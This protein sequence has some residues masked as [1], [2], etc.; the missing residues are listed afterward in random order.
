MRARSAAGM[1]RA[2]TIGLSV[3]A[4]P[5]STGIPHPC[6]S[7]NA[8]PGTGLDGSQGFEYIRGVCP[9][10]TICFGKLTF[11]P[12]QV[13]DPCPTTGSISSGANSS[14]LWAEGKPAGDFH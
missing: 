12:V 10:N 13:S 14:D 4:A 6:F 2:R 1:P 9:D 8:E 7:A 3:I 5:P 11:T